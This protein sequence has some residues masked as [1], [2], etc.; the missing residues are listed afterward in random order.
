MKSHC[1]LLIATVCHLA[2]P[3]LA[4]E[5]PA[6]PARAHLTS[7]LADG[8]PPP[9]E[10][11]K[12]K[13]IVRPEN[14]IAAETHAQGGRQIT[15]QQITPIDLPPPPEAISPVEVTPAMR[16]LWDQRRAQFPRNELIRLSATVYRSK[17][18]P[19]RSLVTYW[20]HEENPAE[21]S[22][23]TAITFWSSADFALLT[24]FA[25]FDGSDGKPRSLFMTWGVQDND[26]I[27]TWLAR[28]GK[29]YQAPKS[30][31]LPVGPAAFKV[32]S[33]EPT[34]DTLIAIQSLHD[35][36]NNEQPRLQAAYEGREKA[37]LL[38]AAEAKAHPPQP[39]NITLNY[40][41]LPST[42]TATQEGGAK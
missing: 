16:A 13:L 41:H 27:S 10:P 12:P 40:W 11:E 38:A 2:S 34:P 15:V 22:A 31:K 24:A 3:G 37:Q 26:R 21:A 23:H 20:Q 19:T 39:K 29:V 25:T 7:P 30:P 4:A 17:N 6:S 14:I 8:T 36:Y 1:F 42:P 32:I 5:A 28:S 9:P 35:L 33:G 18:S